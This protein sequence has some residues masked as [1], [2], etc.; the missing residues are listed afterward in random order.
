M[1]RSTPETRIITE[2]LQPM[3]V[4]VESNVPDHDED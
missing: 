2:L 3:R 4:Q 1:W